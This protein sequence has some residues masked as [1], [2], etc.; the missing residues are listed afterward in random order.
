[1]AQFDQCELGLIAALAIRGRVSALVAM[2]HHAFGSGA[3]AGAKGIRDRNRVGSILR[4]ADQSLGGHI[5]GI[6]LACHTSVMGVSRQFDAGHAKFWMAYPHS[7]H[8]G[9][10]EPITAFVILC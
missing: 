6:L 10:N 7:D 3:F 8:G 5:G 4:V 1:M 2:Q 9:L